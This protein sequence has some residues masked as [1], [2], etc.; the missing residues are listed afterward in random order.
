VPV[1]GVPSATSA[2]G[3]KKPAAR[4]NLFKIDKTGDGWNCHMEEHGFEA[5]NAPVTLMHQRDVVIPKV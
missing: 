1:V 3:G 4:Y 2:P 5:P